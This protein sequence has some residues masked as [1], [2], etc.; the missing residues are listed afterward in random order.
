MAIDTGTAAVISNCLLFLLISGM[1]GSCDAQQ[2]RQ[3]FTTI[4][5]FK[6]IAA[7]LVCQFVLLP[8]LGF[9]AL[10]IFPQSPAT[11][12]S[13]LV[14]TTSPGGGFSGFWCFLSNADLALSV[15]MTT[16]STLASVVA[17][18]RRP[19][20]QPVVLLRRPQRRRGPHI[21]IVPMKQIGSSA[22]VEVPSAKRLDPPRVPVCRA[23]G[24]LR[25]RLVPSERP[26][27]SAVQEGGP[28]L[29]PPPLQG[30]PSVSCP[31]QS[32]P[33]S[34]CRRLRSWRL[35]R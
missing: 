1:A 28:G 5:G 31:R 11:A 6:G 23:A 22:R 27:S 2:L 7:G 35:A 18:P 15:A 29:P 13:L 16:A 8:L 3:R 30:K 19:D 9:V 33:P 4:N 14:V 10:T 32:T 12:I 17:L 24:D 21:S 20:Q 25:L 34:C 26:W